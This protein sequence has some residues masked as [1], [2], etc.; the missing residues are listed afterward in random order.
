MLLLA[1]TWTP[2]GLAYKLLLTA[3]YSSWTDSFRLGNASCLAEDS[4]SLFL[5]RQLPSGEFKLSI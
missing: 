5:D 2:T 4:C 1:P 3:A